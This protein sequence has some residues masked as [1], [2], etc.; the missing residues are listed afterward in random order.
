M[1]GNLSSRWKQISEKDVDAYRQHVTPLSQVDYQTDSERKELVDVRPKGFFIRHPPKPHDLDK[2]I[3]PDAQLFQTIHMGAAVVDHTQWRLILDEMVYH[4]FM[5]N[6]SQLLSMPRTSITTFH[7][8]YSSPIFTPT[9]PV[10]R[11]GNV[12]WTGV[13]LHALLQVAQPNDSASYVWS[14]GLDSGVFADVW[15]DRYQKDLPQ[16]KATAPEVLLAFEINGAPLDKERG[17]PVRLVVPDRRADGPYTTIFYNEIDPNDPDGKR[18]RPVWNVEPNS[19]IVRPR[20]DEV[21]PCGH[22]VTIIGRAWACEEIA[23]VEISIDGESFWRDAQVAPRKEFEWQLFQHPVVFHN[24]SLH[25]I[26]ARAT[27]NC[28]QQQPM[29]N[30]RNQVST[31]AI[32]VSAADQVK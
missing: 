1:L 22:E 3:T 9:N 5:L 7:E 30:R 4:V 6:L 8:C 32:Q 18:K 10:R 24:V 28:G 27:D 26:I 23:R 14:E 29:C 17:G 20:P 13:S 21:I 15:A 31:V 11:V 12:R 19:I 16:E 25:N 2:D